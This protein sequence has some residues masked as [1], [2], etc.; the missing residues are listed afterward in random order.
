M[1]NGGSMPHVFARQMA[2][3]FQYV[4]QNGSIGTD[5]DA[6]T[7]QWAVNGTTLYLLSRLHNSPD[8]SIGELLNEYYLAFGPAALHIKAYFDFWEAHTTSNRAI[9]GFGGSLETYHRRGHEMFP[10]ESFDQAGQILV[11]AANVVADEKNRQYA[12][13]I[14]FLRKG[15]EHAQK[16]A[17]LAKMFNDEKTNTE[18]W[19]EALQDLVGFRHETEH[20]HIA[21]FANS[22]D[23]DRM[24]WGE[25]FK[26]KNDK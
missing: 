6:L 23:N 25:R 8:N 16:E 7:G 21:N 3:E 1:Y 2:E 9:Y 5:F 10:P 14:E 20:M 12:Q 17:K 15:L 22:A 4:Y 26:G 13:R 24:A 19:N 11:E 18:E